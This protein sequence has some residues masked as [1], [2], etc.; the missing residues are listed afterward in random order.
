MANSKFNVRRM[1]AKSFRLPEP[2]LNEPDAP[3]KKDRYKRLWT[4][5][6]AI[7]EHWPYEGGVKLSN[8]EFRQRVIKFVNK[9]IMLSQMEPDSEE[10]REKEIEAKVD[11]ENRLQYEDIVKRQDLI[12]EG[13]DEAILQI[14]KKRQKARFDKVEVVNDMKRGKVYNHMLAHPIPI[15]ERFTG[16]YTCDKSPASPE[17]VSKF[18]GKIFP[19]TDVHA[20]Q[21]DDLPDPGVFTQRP[22]EAD[23]IDELCDIFRQNIGPTLAVCVDGKQFYCHSLVFG[24]LSDLFNNRDFSHVLYLPGSKIQAHTFV[25]IYRWMIEPIQTLS[26]T[27]LVELLQG[28][29]FLAIDE[30]NQQLWQFTHELL[31]DRTH[32]ITMYTISQ[33]ACINVEKLLTPYMGYVFLRYVGSTEFLKLDLSKVKRLLELDTL[34]VNSEMEVSILH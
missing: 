1:E 6:R 14:K 29:N 20:Y 31:K 28:A 7:D 16:T 21:I 25:S 5:I 13:I 2:K 27:Q 10:E 17:E 30:L 24:V 23:I 15:T 3:K 26:L 12:H 9:Q 4:P 19:I 8:S 11:E 22:T 32:I 33:R 34:N 18:V